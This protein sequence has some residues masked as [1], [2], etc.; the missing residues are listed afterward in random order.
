MDAIQN[1]RRTMVV[2]TR[3]LLESDWCNYE[4]QMAQMEGTQTGRDVLLFLLYE[5]IPK[6]ELSRDILFNIQSHTYIEFPRTEDDREPF[7][8]RVAD[9][10]RR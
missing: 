1:S 2:L 10:L 3:A 7:W 4:L 8:N 5:D 6:H 9:A